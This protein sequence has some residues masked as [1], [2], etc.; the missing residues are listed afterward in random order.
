[1]TAIHRVS[2]A[3]LLLGLLAACEPEMVEEA[4]ACSP[5]RFTPLIGSNIAAVTLPADA[6]IR[7]LA[8][9]SV[10]TMDFNPTRV[11]IK[12]N[13]EGVITEVTCG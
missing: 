13:A 6:N 10:M 3:A 8:P 1:M 11:N 12:H 9:N 2:A 5:E 7:V 4:G